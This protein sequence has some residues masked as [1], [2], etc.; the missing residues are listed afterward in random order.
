MTK[1][2]T[3]ASEYTMVVGLQSESNE[4]VTQ[5]PPKSSLAA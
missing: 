5:Q 4:Y 3:F 2:C 1:S